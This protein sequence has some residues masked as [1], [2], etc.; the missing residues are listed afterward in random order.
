MSERSSTRQRMVALTMR[1]VG[2]VSTELTVDGTS[3]GPT[4]MKQ[5]AQ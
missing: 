4:S 1:F 3:E 2:V 5:P